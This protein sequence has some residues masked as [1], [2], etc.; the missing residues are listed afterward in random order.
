MLVVIPTLVITVYVAFLAWALAGIKQYKPVPHAGANGSSRPLAVSVVVAVHNEDSNIGELLKCLHRQALPD[1]KL[2]TLV[3]DDRSTDSTPEILSRWQESHEIEILRISSVPKRYSSKKLALEAGIEAAR[4]RIIVTTDADCRPGEK[5]LSA[6]S[7]C[8][9]SNCIAVV[10][11]SPVISR[12]KWLSALM[13]IDSITVAAH[14]LAGIGWGRPFLA[15][16]RNWAYRKSAFELAGGFSGHRHRLSGDDDLLL[17]R[18][19]KAALGKVEFSLD[20]ESHVVSFGPDSLRDWLLQKRRHLS[21]GRSYALGLQFGYSLF[22]LCNAVIW[23][24]PIIWG[25]PAALYLLAKLAGDLIVLQC[26]C[27]RLSFRMPWPAFLSW[28]LAHLFMHALIGP[29]AFVG[30]IRWKR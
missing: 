25:L 26:T 5:W 7:N 15:T 24:A 9:H 19:A 10:G 8:F 27:K 3:V 21:A 4:N 11:F 14:S 13:T 20:P 6:L 29:F 16:G 23:L 30:R 1:H 28:E 12:N 22:H 2:Q 17:Q 18:M